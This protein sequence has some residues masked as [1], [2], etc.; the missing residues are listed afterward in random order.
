MI[1]KY[2]PPR[3]GDINF[4][5]EDAR[6]K[7]P[8]LLAVMRVGETGASDYYQVVRQEVPE[9][10]GNGWQRGVVVMCAPKYVEQFLSALQVG[11]REMWGQPN[12]WLRVW[13]DAETETRARVHSELSGRIT[14]S[15]YAIWGKDKKTGEVRHGVAIFTESEARTMI[16]VAS[17]WQPDFDYWADTV[18]PSNRVDAS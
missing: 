18:P 12:Y 14:M 15:I 13:R 3:P 17:F 4:V 7:F 2:V 16:A 1:E 10:I 5:A 8:D 9:R 11:I 6:K